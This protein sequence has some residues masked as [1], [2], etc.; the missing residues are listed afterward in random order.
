MVSP[1]QDKVVNEGTMW[2]K[3]KKALRA[4]TKKKCDIAWFTYRILFP[5]IQWEKLNM[6]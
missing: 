6:S 2:R 1:Q 4:H 3:H 5:V